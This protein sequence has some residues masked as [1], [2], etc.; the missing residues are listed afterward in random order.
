MQHV[1]SI[2]ILR[3]LAALAV[4]LVHVLQD[5]QL[6]AGPSAAAFF[7]AGLPLAAGVDLFFVISGFVMVVSSMRLFGQPG[8]AWT[9]MVRRIA[10]I[11]PLYWA[12]TALFLVVLAVTPQALNSAPPPLSDIAR[13]FL[14][15]PYLKEADGLMQPVYKLGWTLNFEM[16]FYVVF[17]VF[18]ALPAVRAV[19]AVSALMIA[20]VAAHLLLQPP[21]G[22]L[23]V[24]TAPI[25]IEFVIGMW[26]GLAFAR[27]VRLPRLA[28]IALM[29]L[30]VTL[31]GLTSA[32]DA[33]MF[34][35]ARL[36]NWGVPAALI[37]AGGALG[38]ADARAEGFVGQGFA[39]L[40][41]ASYALYLAHPFL[42]RGS[43]QLV[44]KAGFA[45]LSG[46]LLFTVAAVAASVIAALA[47][48][49]WFEKPLTAR[50][51]QQLGLPGKPV[52][53]HQR[54]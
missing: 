35:A 22:L 43:R 7:P 21:P 38:M 29:A 19:A 4:V 13:S 15:I 30:G 24:W 12:L 53:V 41:D 54:A 39:R 50:L 32:Q 46:A 36:L 8:A 2:Q 27:G 11:V 6:I 18:V 9:F 28:G 25:I 26:I 51:Q 17:A 5:A 52:S 40:G 44:E 37:I 34:G 10:R 42:L 31:L 23:H 47:I 45:G 33:D 48:Y 3:A 1:A 16:M 49:R 20:L 14:F